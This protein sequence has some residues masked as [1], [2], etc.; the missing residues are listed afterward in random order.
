V[1]DIA[2]KATSQAKPHRNDQKSHQ[3]PFVSCGFDFECRENVESTSRCDISIS[4]LPTSR[5]LLRIADVIRANF[6]YQLLAISKIYV[7]QLLAR[8]CA[9]CFFRLGSRRQILA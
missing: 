9:Y 5:R 3:P 7:F 4:E 2:S 1:A 8:I 6:M